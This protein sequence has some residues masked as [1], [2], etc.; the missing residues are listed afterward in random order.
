M[1]WLR[2]QSEIGVS[3]LLGLYFEEQNWEGITRVARETDTWFP[4]YQTACEYPIAQACFEGHA[5]ME[6]YG[7]LTQK[8]ADKIITR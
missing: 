6:M 2:K 5:W 4:V 3:V 7:L 1:L 8:F